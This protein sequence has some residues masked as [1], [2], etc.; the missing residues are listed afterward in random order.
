MLE[1]KNVCC[2]Y[3]GIDIVKQVSFN[4][5]RGENLCIVGP[6]G[7]GKSTLLK[8]IS[9]LISF[10]GEIKLD[11]KN[12][13]A[14]KRKELATKIALMTQSSNIQ[15]PYTIFETVA[16]GRYA[17]LNSIFSRLS[18]KDEEVINE[19]LKMVGLLD[20]KDKLISEL[21]GGQLQRVFL[22]RAFSQDPEVI[23]LD[24]PTN[25]L[26]LRCQIEILDYLKSWAKEKNKI[27][28]AVLHDLNLVQ[29][30]GDRVLMLNDG[31]I[32][33]NGNTKEVLNSN[34]LEEVYGIDIKTFM[35]RTLEKWK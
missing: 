25:H 12:I 7:C 29:N 11:G 34:D 27:V 10:N 8:A 6:N 21:S 35:V 13:N 28:I 4:I 31:V 1:V 23:L 3:N 14:L 17:H 15:F 2:G 9:N 19:S 32:K 18:K 30:Y 5:N 26:D 22:A 16:L 33:G 24:E 20:I